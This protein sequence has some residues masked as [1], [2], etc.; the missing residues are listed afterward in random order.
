[1]S[2]EKYMRECAESYQT[3]GDEDGYDAIIMAID[4]VAGAKKKYPDRIIPIDNAINY[5]KQELR[6]SGYQ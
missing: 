6:G 4:D 3:H 1:M 2:R 5:A